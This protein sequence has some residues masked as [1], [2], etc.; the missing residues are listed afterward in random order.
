MWA[1]D[2]FGTDTTRMDCKASSFW[3]GTQVQNVP[4]YAKEMLIAD[5]GFEIFEADNKQLEGR[6]TAYCSME[7]AL[8]LA[9]EDAHRDFYK[10][11]GTLFFD[12]PYEEVTDFFRNKVLKRIVHGTNYMMGSQDLHREYRCVRILLETAGK[13]GIVI[14]E[15]P[16]ANRP[17]HR[18]LHQFAKDLLDA[19]HKPFPRVREWYKEIEEEIRI[20]A[21]WFLLQAKCAGS[22]ETLSASTQCCVLRWLTSSTAFC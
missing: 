17:N 11:F 7:E 19:Y 4:G 18:T 22:S 13:L 5:E 20:L 16:R 21:S 2:P 15:T 1:L 9:L 6:T 12:I 14:V 10:T 3:V 8:I